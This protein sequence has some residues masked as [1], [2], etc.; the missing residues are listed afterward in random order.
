MAIIRVFAY[1]VLGHWHVTV[2]AQWGPTSR[3]AWIPIGEGSVLVDRKGTILRDVLE[4]L[5][6]AG[7]L[8]ANTPETDVTWPDTAWGPGF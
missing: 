7:E 2:G 5:S 3:R 8:A 4:V 6:K 1:D